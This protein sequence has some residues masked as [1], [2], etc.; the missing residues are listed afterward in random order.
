MPNSKLSTLVDAFTGTSINTGLWNNIT[1]GA[2]TLDTLND[3]VTLAQPTVNGT[4]NTFG[5]NGLFD[6]TSSS[7]YAQIGTS[8]V[9]NGGT[10]TIFKLLLDANNSVAMRL[11]SGVFKMTLQT[12]GTTVTTTLPGYDPN[13]H[14]WWRLREAAG[15]FYADASVDGASWVNLASSS[16]SWSAT[17]VMFVFQTG[18]TTTEAAGNV[19]WLAHVNTPQGGQFNLGWPQIG[20]DWAPYWNVNAGAQPLDR[21]ASV[22]ARTRGRAGIRRGRQYE[23]DQIRSGTLDM[24]LA[25]KDGALDPL[26]SGG[27]WFGNI[28]PYQ[29]TRVRAQWPPSINLLTPVQATGGDAGGY[30]TGAIPATQQGISVFTDT[31]SSNGTITASTSAWQ[32][33]NVFQFS[34]PASTAV[35]QRVCYTPQPPV[36]PGGTYTVQIRVRNVTASTSIQVYPHIGWYLTANGSATYTLGTAVT[37]TG[38]ATA[39]WTTLTLTATVPPNAMAMN[40]GVKVAAIPASTVSVQVDGW[41]LEVG[42]QASVWTMPGVVYPMYS[43]FIERW[44]SSWT[45]SGTYGLVSPTGV[46]TLSLLSQRVLRDPLTEEIYS[47]NPRFLLTLA[48]P[49]NAQSFTDA[50]GAYPPTPLAV[51]KY[52]AG[53]LTSGNQI[54]ATNTTTGIYTGSTGTVVTVSNP[55][56]GTNLVD[57]AT[58]I[59]LGNSGITGPANPT[60]AWTRMIALRYTG[61]TPTAKSVLWSCFDNQRANDLP[62][63]SMIQIWIGTDGKPIFYMQGPSGAASSI[64]FGGATN[65]VDGNWHLLMFGYNSSTAQIIASQDGS[66]SAFVGG[67]SA[68]TVATGLVSDNVG[69]YVD[70]SAGNGTAYNYKGDLSYVTEFPGFFTNGDIIAVYTAWKNSFVGDSSNARYNRILGWAGFSGPTSIQTGLTTSMGAA[71]TGGQDALTALQ[72][73]VD[74]ENGEHFVDRSG[75]VTFRAR[76]ARYNALTPTYIFGERTDLGEIPYEE[77]QLDYDPTR[78]AN[79]VKVTQASSSQ[80]FSAQDSTSISNYF[81]RQLTR[82]VNASSTQECQ[83]SANYLLG[84]YKNPAVRVSALKLHPSANPSLLWPVCLSLELGTRIRVM[85][86]PPSPAAAIQVECFVES[87]QWDLD[88]QGEAFVTLQCSPADLTPYGIFASFHTTLNASISSGVTS[89]VIKNGADNTNP[90]AAQ[91]PVGGQLVLGQNTANQETVTIASVG[92][93][94][95]GWTTATITLTAATTKSH[96]GGDT[97]CEPLPAGVTDPTTWDT[98]SKFDSTAFAY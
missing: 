78:L 57:P 73:V 67:V 21:Y 28:T 51:S 23:L 44:P 45:M 60:V 11:E 42:S 47:R 68:T 66:L 32:G 96:S 88:D 10:R 55:D 82:T 61:P 3:L 41:Q 34:V 56:P 2:A 89:V 9:G 37:L 91:L 58:F 63:G 74:T 7:V 87:I 53:T 4:V 5:A 33:S 95:P 71:A 25:N 24:T 13:A 19:A 18:A 17:G 52:G 84:R 12:A 50:I 81:P 48:D 97:V 35:N 38:S 90:A 70:P 93:T 62:S 98:V 1:G 15:M 80:V 29:P 26:N 14:R 59:S 75:V 49:Q 40:V 65:V 46:D 27:P 92:T 30:P 8:P 77:V 6:A 16:Y 76:S 31:D 85:R 22:T 79:Q 54:T 69:G 94:S 72:A 36:T 86:R 39:A 43:G 20:Y 83:D 64:V